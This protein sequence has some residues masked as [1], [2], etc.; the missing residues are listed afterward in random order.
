MDAT[1]QP[2]AMMGQH[3]R[4]ALA[5]DLVIIGTSSARNCPGL[6]QEDEN[7][8][9]LEDALGRVGAAPF[10]LDL[11]RA[12]EV[13]LL[14]S[15]LTRLQSMRADSTTQILASPQDAFDALVLIDPLTP[16]GK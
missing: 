11:R 12:R 10:L 14:T 9:S 15:W 6:P 2:P 1:C 13:P 16:A 4:A 5:K 8:C 3:L 7:R